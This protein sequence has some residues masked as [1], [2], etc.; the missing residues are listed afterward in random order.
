MMRTIICLI[1]A[2]LLA[3]FPSS[4]ASA[5]E[6]PDVLPDAECVTRGRLGNGLTYY[7]VKDDGSRGTADLLF[8][9]FLIEDGLPVFRALLAYAA[10]RLFGWIA[11]NR[12]TRELEA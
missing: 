9:C 1:L 11:W 7:I 12:S 4:V 10:V 2:V 5:A 8:L 6:G 3:A